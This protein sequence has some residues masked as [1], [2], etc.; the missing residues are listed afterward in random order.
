MDRPDMDNSKKINTN[1]SGSNWFE[2]EDGKQAIGD[3]HFEIYIP[4][5]SILTIVEDEFGTDL[6]IGYL[7][8]QIKGE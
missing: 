5:K 2:T 1:E 3:I 6:F 7:P 4:S 8:N